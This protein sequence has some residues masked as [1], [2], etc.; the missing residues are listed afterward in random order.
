MLNTLRLIFAV[1]MFGKHN[2]R[3]KK[4]VKKLQNSENLPNN[5]DPTY[6]FSLY[7]IGED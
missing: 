4:L 1:K 6:P 3:S 5:V 2:K 7:I